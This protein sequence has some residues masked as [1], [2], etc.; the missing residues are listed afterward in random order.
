MIM[1][2]KSQCRRATSIVVAVLGCHCALSE[3]HGIM[4]SES[5]IIMMAWSDDPPAGTVGDLSL[6]RLCCMSLPLQVRT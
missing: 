6:R 2:A 1:I 5:L 4:D 3:A